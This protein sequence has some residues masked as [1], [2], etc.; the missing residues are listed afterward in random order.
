MVRRASALAL[1]ILAAASLSAQSVIPNNPGKKPAVAIRNATIH[2]VTSAPIPNGTIVFSGGVITAVGA[3]VA[4][5]EHAT[6]IDGTGLSVYPGLIDSGTTLGLTEID[7]VPG[8]VDIAEIGDLNPNAMAAVAINPHSNLIP[9][10]RING[11]TAA[12]TAPQGGLISGQDALI[13]LAGWTPQEMVVKAPVGMHINFPRVRSAPFGDQPQDEEAEKEARKSYRNE[14][15][16]LR[17]ILRDAQAYAK[18][19]AAR[20]RDR[21]VRRFDRD[22]LLE[23]LVPVVEGRLPVIMHANLERDIRAAIKFA[24]EMKLKMIL[25]GGQDVAKVIPELESRNIPVILGPILALPPREDDPYD[26]LFTNA[27][28]LHDNGIR[29]AIQSANSHDVRNLPYH[30]AACAAFGLPKDVALKAITIF[31]AEIF[32]VADKMGS[33]EPGK[34]ANVIVTDGDPLEIRTTV[35]R[36]YIAGEEIPMDS[37]Q[38]LLYEKFRQRP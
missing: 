17:E 37:H 3:N 8:T 5:P 13:Q 6:V 9:V 12:I 28:V 22:L 21:S 18:A 35:R 19:A 14:I 16:K 23:A 20:E 10:S 31:P 7:S 11:V 32:G 33:L 24:D 1:L 36:V 29:F 38:T 30:A 27:K 4:V 15:E 2:P 34:M 26:L 25:S